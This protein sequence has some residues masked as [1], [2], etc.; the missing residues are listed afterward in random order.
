MNDSKSEK[1][2]FNLLKSGMFW[3]IYP[4]LTGDWDKDKDEYIKNEQWLNENFR[5][6]KN[7]RIDGIKSEN[8][9]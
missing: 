1:D 7:R 2:Y 6:N 8:I 4:Q 9:E 3:E 5:N